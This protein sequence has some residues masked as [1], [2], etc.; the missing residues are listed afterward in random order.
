[1]TV[2]RAVLLVAMVLPVVV[3]MACGQVYRP[4]VI[5]CSTGGVPGCPVEANPQPGNFHEV[6]GITSNLPSNAGA[7]MQIDVSG[8]SLIGETATSTANAPNSG[9]NPTHMAIIPNDARLFVA[10]AAS[11]FP[12]GV[13]AV[14]S[15]SPAFQSSLA[16]GFGPV[17]M[18]G[19]PSMTGQTSQISALSETGNVVTATLTASL[20]ASPTRSDLALVGTPIVVTGEANAGFSGYN[21]TFTISSIS[22]TTVQYV[23]ATASALPPCA[24]NALPTPPCPSG[25]TMSI[26]VQPVYLASAEN[27]AMYVANFTSNSIAK[28]NTATNVVTNTASVEPAVP[29]PVT[30][31]PNPVSMAETPNA[32]KLYV[33][34]QGNNTVTSFNPVDLSTNV[35][36]GF[37]GITPVWVVARGDSQKV[38]VLTQ[39]DGQLVTIDVATDTVT[40]SLPVGVGAN[41]I[42]FDP[43]LNRLYV[44][45]PV[46]QMVYVFSD[47]GGLLN[48][49]VSDVPLQLAAISFTSGA[50]PCAGGCT[51]VSV[52]ALLDGTRFYVATYQ[53]P[54][55]CPS[56]TGVTGACVVPGLTVFNANTFALQY[57]NAPTLEL[58]V[59]PPPCVV[60]PT[61]SCTTTWPFAAGQTAVPP[62]ASCATPIY[63]ALY[64]PSSTLFPTRFRVFTAAAA[65]SSR[66]YVGLCDA[67]VIA[68]IN[69]TDGN[70]NNPGTQVPPDSLVTDLPTAPEANSASALQNPKFLLMGQ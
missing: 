53:A 40:S 36:T 34:N 58:L 44:T 52:T 59:G 18:I 13:D 10:A 41:F 37:T 29:A 51:P 22:S 12:G 64:S 47:T 33:A 62:A 7:T 19:L 48:G 67:G 3:W 57:P 63:P 35:V 38:Y 15:F 42:F 1:M 28:I 65:D 2:R 31:A 55:A 5:P 30:P 9:F 24:P 26:P 20:L 14:A 43:N 25:G 69:T 54:T 49:V 68:I 61:N 17:S 50:G 70:T 16:T 23:D 60:S 66:V 27:T 45:N 8:D 11:V 46:T 56:G 39:G 21:G 6:F 32:F 4:V